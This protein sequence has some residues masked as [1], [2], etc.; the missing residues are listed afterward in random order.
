MKGPVTPGII[1]TPETH[2]NQQHQQHQSQ[3]QQQQ[4]QTLL[5]Q[6]TS[7]PTPKRPSPTRSTSGSSVHSNN[8]KLNKKKQSNSSSQPPPMRAGSISTLKLPHPGASTL[9]QTQ[10]PNQAK[11]PLYSW[12][13]TSELDD[14]EASSGYYPAVLRER[15]YTMEYGSFIPS[16]KRGVYIRENNDTDEHDNGSEYSDYGHTPYLSKSPLIHILIN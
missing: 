16:N 10:S 15:I 4:H 3:S 14:S 9:L 12:E 8:S 2:S 7:K 5:S 13:V 1:N 11:K 6:Q